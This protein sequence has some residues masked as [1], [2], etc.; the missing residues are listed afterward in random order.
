M[1]ITLL[2]LLCLKTLPPIQG[3]IKATVLSPRPPPSQLS[4]L[5]KRSKCSE[6]QLK[7]KATES[8][9]ELDNYLQQLFSG[10]T[11][12]IALLNFIFQIFS[13]IDFISPTMTGARAE[14]KSRHRW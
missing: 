14:T 2:D 12:S 13:I 11:P 7:L 9:I 10:G 5:S 3:I 6:W 8:E 4:R 1:K